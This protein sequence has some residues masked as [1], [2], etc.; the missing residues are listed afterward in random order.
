M[1]QVLKEI[2]SRKGFVD[3]GGKWVKD[4]SPE[5]QELWVE[6]NFQSCTR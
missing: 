6:A 5:A 4:K 1:E 3:R 2:N